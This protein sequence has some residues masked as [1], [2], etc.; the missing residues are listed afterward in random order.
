MFQSTR[1]RGARLPS[2]SACA[3]RGKFQSTRPRG[4][5]PVFWHSHSRAYRVSIHAPAR[6]A[7][8]GKSYMGANGRV[9]IHAPARG[10]TE[11]V[12]ERQRLSEFQ[13]TRPRG[14]RPTRVSTSRNPMGFNPRARAGRDSN[15]LIKV[16]VRPVSIH[17]PARGATAELQRAK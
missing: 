13:S 1:P 10:A 9:S 5:R 6:G 7:T 17:A 15:A 11:A 8:S 12:S 16:E 14:A 2:L 4:A 3:Y